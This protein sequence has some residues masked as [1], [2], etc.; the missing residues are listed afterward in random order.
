MI[1]RPPRSTLFPYTTLFR[2]LAGGALNVSPLFGGGTWLHRWLEPVTAAADRLQPAVELSRATEG[3]LVLGAVAVAALGIFGALRLLK[4]EALVPARLA[5]PETGLGR[6]LWKK[7]YV[8]ELYDA[9]LVRPVMWLSREVLW[10][11][12]DARLVDG[13]LVNGSAAAS[14]ALG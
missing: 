11:V 9:V 12:V 8:D 1:R 2:S 10:K 7:W 6:V 4:P 13:L 5:P 3:A 14:R